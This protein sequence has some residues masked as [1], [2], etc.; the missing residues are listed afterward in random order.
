MRQERIQQ[1]AAARREVKEAQRASGEKP[2]G[3]LARALGR[4]RGRG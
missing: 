1:A 3:L 4:L 2:P